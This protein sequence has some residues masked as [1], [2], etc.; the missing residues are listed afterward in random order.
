MMFEKV[1]LETAVPEVLSNSAWMT[2]HT[3]I[4]LAYL[5]NTAVDAGFKHVAGDEC[6]L[7][8]LKRFMTQHPRFPVQADVGHFRDLYSC[9]IKAVLHRI[10]RKTAVM[11]PSRETLFLG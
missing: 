2:Q 8:S 5:S 4:A 7:Q 11:F 3:Q 1:K 9:L 6:R 10:E